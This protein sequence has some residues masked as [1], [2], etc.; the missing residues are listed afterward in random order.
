MYEQENYLRYY[1]KLA[2]SYWRLIVAAVVIAGASAF[3]ITSMRD[4]VYEA[5]AT[6]AILRSRTEVELDPR[7]RTLQEGANTTAREEGLVALAQ[8]NQVARQV[9]DEVGEQL[10]PEARELMT[11]RD[12]VE[13]NIT[14]DLINITV[15]HADPDVA[16]E[17]ANSWAQT[18]EEHVNSVYANSAAPSE[19]NIVAQVEAAR[20]DYE[21]AQ[22]EL[23]AFISEDRVMTLEREIAVREALLAGYQ[24]TLI[25]MRVK[26]VTT[27]QAILDSYYSELQ[28]IEGWMAD[29]RS[30]LQQVQD[31]SGSTAGDV[32]NA[33]AFVLLQGKISNSEPPSVVQSPPEG[34]G[35]S[36]FVGSNNNPMSL[37]V[38]V[39]NV[40]ADGVDS[41]DVNSLI[42]TL[43]SRREATVDRIDSLQTSISTG[44]ESE[45]EIAVDYSQLEQQITSF[46]EEIAALQSE[47][48]A[49]TALRQDLTQARDRN[50]DTY[51]VLL[52]RQVEEEIVSESP[53]AEVRLAD[54]AVV[55]SEPV[56]RGIIRNS[57]LAATVAF[58]FAVGVILL[59]DWWAWDQ[60]AVGEH[61]PEVHERQSGDAGVETATEHS[62]GS[63]QL[64][65]PTT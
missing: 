44:D 10:D 25:D 42:R 39:G 62:S 63:R 43:E 20:Q 15:R 35:G 3:I 26:P 9:L 38:E 4:H 29:A 54:P 52:G 45:N 41:S 17:I 28:Q 6:V 8:S 32:G 1:V 59:V 31:T 27:D 48:E 50:L 30:L 13:A 24:E 53:A 57:L 19:S 12:M 14:G 23:E 60:P 22:E 64:S 33:V 56:G 49:Q 36:I 37:Q 46:E 47:V 40:L 55:P 61:E 58:M 2:L 16:A 5:R 18:Y 34:A 21:A 7:I 65:N 11:I 51:Q